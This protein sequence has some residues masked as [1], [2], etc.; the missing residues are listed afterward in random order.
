MRHAQKPPRG[1]LFILCALLVT[2]LTTSTTA[3]YPE[4]DHFYGTWDGE[5]KYT[6][7]ACMHNPPQQFILSISAPLH[8]TH[9]AFIVFALQIGD[10]EIVTSWSSFLLYVSGELE[11]SVRLERDDNAILALSGRLNFGERKGRTGEGT[12]FNNARC[13]GT[14]TV[15]RRK[16]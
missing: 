5:M 11:G 8:W 6:S 16:E 15:T 9:T 10:E 13:S 12:W 3:H 4:V 1:R 14:W 7:L 2:L